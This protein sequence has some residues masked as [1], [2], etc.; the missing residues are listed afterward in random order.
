MGVF[1]FCLMMSFICERMFGVALFTTRGKVQDIVG[2]GLVI[3][4]NGRGFV[5]ILKG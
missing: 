1:G 4:D 2:I 3:Q 5:I